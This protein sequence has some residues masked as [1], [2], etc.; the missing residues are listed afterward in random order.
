MGL[1]KTM[2][3]LAD[4]TRRTILTLL[5]SG[6]LTA[7][8]LAA[9]FD[10]T[11]PAVSKHLSVLRAAGLVRDRRAGKFIRYELNASVIEEALL[12]LENFRRN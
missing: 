4:P 3:A 8:E 10:M 7:G 2:K 12:W 1:Q 5:K 9:H 11:L 6:S